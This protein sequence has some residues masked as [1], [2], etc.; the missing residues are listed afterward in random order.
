MST[1][2]TLIQTARSL[3][4]DQALVSYQG[5]Y[6]GAVAAVSPTEAGQ[7]HADLNYGEVFVRDNVPVMIYLL[8]DNRPGI[9][10]RFLD[11]CLQLQQ[12]EGRSRGVFPNSFCEHQGQLVADYG[13]RAIGRVCAYDASLW[14]PILSWIYVQHTG[15]RAWASQPALQAALQRF[16]TL[17]LQPGF[18]D[19]PLLEVADG[20][21]MID[22]PLDVWGS[23]LEVQA[24]LY[25]A[26]QSAAALLRLGKTPQQAES[27]RL[28]TAA[29]SRASQLRQFLLKHYWITAS[30]LEQTRRQP[31]EQYGDAIDNEY[32]VYPAAIPD[33]LQPWLAP[34]GGYLMG[35]VRTGRPD[36]RFFTLGNCLA[37][38]FGILPLPQQAS[39]FRLMVHHQDALIGQMPL[40]ICHPPLSETQWQILTGFDPK[41]RPG[42]YHNG[43]YW[44]CLTW[45]WAIAF[46]RYQ[47][48]AKSTD[49]EDADLEKS[50]QQALQNGF[51]Y[52]QQL[53]QRRWSEYF[54]G[55]SGGWIGQQS[56]DYQTWTFVGFLL[57]QHF[58][59]P[60]AAI[61]IMGLPS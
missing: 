60:Q 16:L 10:R 40:R 3:L 58:L 25:G 18:R 8:L 33:W 49:A 9:V 55:P 21:F 43:G 38:L 48:E 35:N 11:C 44:P 37:A 19:T 45:F 36:F 4:Y 29:I 56:R 54:D 22:R 61:N 50:C 31:T 17:I 24:L 23:P 26:L 2:E 39:L 47:A 30:T 51:S 57:T 52:M 7:F 46:R 34:D 27:D 14:V 41:N 15:D 5:D 32:N 13:Q 20:A 12:T 42:C 59:Q 6:I 28:I 53:P 1:L